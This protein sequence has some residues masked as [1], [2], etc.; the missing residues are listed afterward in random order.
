MFS[1][2]TGDGSQGSNPQGYSTCPW[3]GELGSP[4]VTG[5]VRLFLI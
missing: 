1:L 2:S 5:V 4:L 3:M